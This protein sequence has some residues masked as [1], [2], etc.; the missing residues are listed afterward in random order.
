MWTDKDQ[1]AIGKQWV[2][3]QSREKLVVPEKS[4]VGL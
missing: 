4:A 3:R 1:R 2:Y